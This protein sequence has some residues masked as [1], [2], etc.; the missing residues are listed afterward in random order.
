MHK[1]QIMSGAQLQNQSKSSRC[2]AAVLAC[3]KSKDICDNKDDLVPISHRFSIYVKTLREQGH[4]IE[5]FSRGGRTKTRY[6]GFEERFDTTGL[7]ES[8]YQ[9]A[10]WRRKRQERLEFDDYRCC[11]C[12]STY[13][14]QVHHWCYDLFNEDIEDL[15]TLCRVCHEKLH[16]YEQ[17]SIAFPRSVDRQTYERLKEQ[18]NRTKELEKANKKGLLF[19]LSGMRTGDVDG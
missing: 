5:S 18:V 3:L 8:Y 4:Q 1:E 6:V 7:K 2:L 13:E 16:A 19:E 10:H 15:S 14:L 9:T 17:V 12:R 11:H